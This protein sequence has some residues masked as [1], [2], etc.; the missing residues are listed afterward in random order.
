M[1]LRAPIQ[2]VKTFGRYKKAGEHIMARLHNPFPSIRE[3]SR[4]G[5][6]Q[7]SNISLSCPLC[8]RKATATLSPHTIPF[9]A[10]YCP[11]CIKYAVQEDLFQKFD[12][13]EHAYLLSGEMRHTQENM[14]THLVSAESAKEIINKQLQLESENRSMAYLIWHYDQKESDRNGWREYIEYPAVAY[15]KDK[16]DL[17][18]I[19]EIAVELGYLEKGDERYKPTVSGVTFSSEER[20][21]ESTALVD[22][23]SGKNSARQRGLLDLR[24]FYLDNVE[25]S[26]Y[27]YRFRDVVV[28]VNETR[29]VFCGIQETYDY[30]F[31][32][33]DTEEAIEKF[34][35]LCM[36]ENENYDKEAQCWFYLILYYLYKHGYVLEQFPKLVERPPEDTYDF[37]NREIRTRLIADG[38]E[39]NGT[40]GYAIRRTFVGSFTFKQKNQYIDFGKELEAKF[41]R[42]STR[43]AEFQAMS[44]DEKLAEIVN[45]IENLLKKDDKYLK[46][47]YSEIC[48]AFLNDDIIKK[49]KKIL[50]CFRHSAEHSI[51]ER[52]TF[53]DDKKDFFID[54]GIVIVKTIH[55]L[56]EINHQK[57]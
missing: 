35:I 1:L 23:I 52:S 54:F 2:T 4:K 19:T 13:A 55:K 46:L 38:K 34:K 48:E 30:T 18:N 42:I 43:D 44:R 56:L 39:S 57:E 21:R 31:E 37:V 15:C 41:R 20:K 7:K 28:H 53:T 10:V 11:N 6:L 26:E 17:R 36:S 40:E 9:I 14:T 25:Q 33:F 24:K 32:V 45:L 8:G 12:D 27:Y 49:Y 51:E 29:N 16:E 3:Q 5:Q 22:I 47:N 50:Q